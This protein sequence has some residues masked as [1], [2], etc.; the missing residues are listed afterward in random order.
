[1]AR[2]TILFL[3]FSYCVCTCNTNGAKGGPDPW[4]LEHIKEPDFTDEN[5]LPPD[6]RAPLQKEKPTDT[7]FGWWFKRLLT[8]VLK[9]G[10]VK[11][12]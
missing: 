3:L 6:L 9:S 7:K 12:S 11:V 5:P 10:Q 8:I 2:S 4:H 1:M